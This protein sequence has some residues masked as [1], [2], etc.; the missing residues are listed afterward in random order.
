[1]RYYELFEDL[2]PYGVSDQIANSVV[3]ILTPLA[4]NGVQYVTVQQVL[5]DLKNYG[6]GVSIDRSLLIQILDPN[7]IKLIKNIEG[8]RINLNNGDNGPEISQDDKEQQKSEDD[9]KKTAASQA[10]KNIG[11]S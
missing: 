11:N 5:D 2:D 9:I 10:K 6:T 1:M 3:D 4:S 8:D 7:K